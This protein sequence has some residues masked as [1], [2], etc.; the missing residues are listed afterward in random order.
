MRESSDTAAWCAQRASRRLAEHLGNIVRAAGQGRMIVL[1]TEPRGPTGWQCS[2]CGAGGVFCAVPGLSGRCLHELGLGEPVRRCPRTTSQQGG[3][4]GTVEEIQKLERC[5][6]FLAVQLLSRS[7][8]PYWSR[9]VF[10]YSVILP[11]LT[12]WTSTQGPAQ[13]RPFRD[14]ESV[15]RTTAWSSLASTSCISV[16]GSLT[17]SDSAASMAKTW[18]FPW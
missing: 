14:T 1:W 12:C 7:S 10:Q 6:R 4:G 16:V 13:V 18:S 5:R 9:E 11:S 2:V 15:L 8:Y 3:D 17:S